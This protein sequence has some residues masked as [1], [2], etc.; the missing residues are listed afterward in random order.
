[1][2]LPTLISTILRLINQQQQN[3]RAISFSP[4]NLDAHV[5]YENEYI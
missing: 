5:I 2:L 3:L 4:P 1:M